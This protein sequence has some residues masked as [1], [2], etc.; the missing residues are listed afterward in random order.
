MNAYHRLLALV[1]SV[2]LAAF[3][4]PALAAPTKTYSL[5]ATA[6]PT[7][8]TD[9]NGQR[10]L[11][12]PVPVA[13]TIKNESPPS[14]ANSNISSFSFTAAGMT[15]ASVD[16][17]ACQSLGGI[18]ALDTSTN[19]VSVTNISPPVQAQGTFTVPVTV[20]SCGDGAWSAKVWSGS[21]LNGNLFALVN[22]AS[23]PSNSLTPVDCG[24]TTCG[25][26]FVTSSLNSVAG[27]PAY[28]SGL[29]GFYDKNGAACTT[30]G[31]TVTNTIPSNKTVHFEYPSAS[32]FNPSTDPAAAFLYTLNFGTPV[33]LTLAWFTDS[34]GPVFVA[35]QQCLTTQMANNLPAPYGSLGQNVSATKKQIPVNV[36]VAPTIPLPFPIVVDTE[37]ML[38]TSIS[39][40]NWTVQ[41][42]QGGTTAAP[43]AAGAPVM[44][45]PLP[46]L[47]GPF[48]QAQSSAGYKV[49]NQ[50]QMCIAAPDISQGSS[51]SYN[52]IDIG[53][54][55][56]Q[57]F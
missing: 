28:V 30:I 36:T 12:V 15:I 9:S 38:V 53:D 41:R 32:S 35:G 7:Y 23:L 5:N 22:D 43:H 13:I 1:V 26:P 33:A 6:S 57:G 10:T 46:I 29:R 39:T 3:A 31:Y 55:W 19:T 17:G 42:G 24:D 27:S 34:N 25:L 11:T 4:L 56:G 45:T 51:S 18:C 50:A 52:V 14:V 20:V 44:S 48:T 37:R 47:T 54:G 21:Q 40:N 8:G 49:G 2:A 16:T